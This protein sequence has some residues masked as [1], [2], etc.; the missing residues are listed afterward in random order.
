MSHTP[1]PWHV[2]K[3]YPTRVNGPEDAPG[4]LVDCGENVEYLEAITNARLI[5]AAPDLLAACEAVLA[6]LRY[7]KGRPVMAEFKMKDF[8][9]NAIAKAKGESK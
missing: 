4:V 6:G 7:E 9:S 1:G 2:N 3:K 8:L 5:A